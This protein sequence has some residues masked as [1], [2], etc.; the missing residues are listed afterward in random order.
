MLCCYSRSGF[1]G[2]GIFNMKLDVADCFIKL[3]PECLALSRHQHMRI[4]LLDQVLP[5]LAL[6]PL[7]GVIND[8]PSQLVQVLLVSLLL[9]GVGITSSDLAHVVSYRW[10]FGVHLLLVVQVPLLV[11]VG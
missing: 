1:C 11:Y 10:V 7:V 4:W 3:I 9:L 5:L 6:D 8:L 2:S